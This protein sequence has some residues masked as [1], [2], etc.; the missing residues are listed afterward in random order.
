MAKGIKN[1]TQSE[2]SMLELFLKEYDKLKSEQI[3][4]LGFRDNL[5]YA[6]LIAMTGIIAIGATDVVRILLL[7][8]LPMICVVLGWVYLVNDEKIS[9]I[10][11]YIRYTLTDKVKEAA[12]IT[13]PNI[14]GWE[15]AHRS[16]E[17]RI[18]RKYIQLFV[19][20]F[21]FVLPGFVAI[22]IF[23][24]N[25]PNILVP[26]RW[27]AIVEG[28]LLAFLGIQIYIYADLKKGK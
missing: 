14:F 16:D 3:Q 25:A 27:I 20:L 10:G 1:M 13:D 11:R 28:I 4:R 6:N 2:N 22:T 18:S 23:W 26:L 19:D 5:I 21:V 12:K 15:T 24:L 8:I 17:R 7:L 9:A